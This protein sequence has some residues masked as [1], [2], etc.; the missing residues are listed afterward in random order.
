MIDTEQLE[1]EPVISRPSQ[2]D[3]STGRVPVIPWASRLPAA[4]ETHANSVYKNAKQTQFTA[5]LGQERGWRKKQS[6]FAAGTSRSGHGVRDTIHEIRARHV[7][8]APNKANP[9]GWRPRLGIADCRLGIRQRETPGRSAALCAKQTQSLY[10]LWAQ[11]R[12]ALH[13]EGGGD[14]RKQSQL[15]RARRPRLRIGNLRR[16]AI[17]NPS[18][19]CKT[20]P[21]CFVL[22]RR[23]RVIEE[24]TQFVWQPQA[25][26]GDGRLAFLLYSRPAASYTLGFR[27][28]PC[29]L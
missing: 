14:G 22:G 12:G 19:P 21:I 5:F 17:P 11:L 29:V 24:R 16:K 7:D 6:Q 18:A 10:M 1:R 23:T 9:G 3:A 28:H 8:G 15:A 2:P 27:I 26:L 25:Q 20:K 13:I 4:P